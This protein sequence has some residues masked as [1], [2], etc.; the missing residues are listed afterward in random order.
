MRHYI[1]LVCPIILLLLI[2]SGCE[3][4]IVNEYAGD[5]P[6][7]GTA[8]CFGCHSDNDFKLVAARKQYDMSAHATGDTYN[9]NRNNS[10]RYSSCE[11][12][13][14][15]E[16][17]VAAATGEPVTADEFTNVSCFTCHE[18]HTNGTLALRTTEAVTLLNKEVFDHGAGNLCA[19]CHHSRTDVDTEV[20]ANDTLNS[21]YGPHH[22]NQ[23][24]MLIGTN[25]YE[26]EDYD[27]TSAHAHAL[28]EDACLQ[29][30]MAAPLYGT[31]G[32]SFYLANEEEEY[33]NVKGCNT[34]CH[35]GGVE[36]F[37]HN[38]LQADIKTLVDSLGAILLEA[39]LLEEVDDNGV[40][41]LEP[42]EDRVVMTADSLGAVFNY[43]YVLEDRSM[44][45]HNPYYAEDLLKSSIDFMNG[46][47]AKAPGQIDLRPL[48]AH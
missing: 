42:T 39:G 38:D 23:S 3:R 10:S 37:E 1:L 45:I 16:G 32:H 27:Y 30:H 9:R 19:T 2:A 6:P 40:T 5:P 18:P 48:A 46:T 8:V 15:N 25:A 33:D 14:T 29:C 22:S 20:F 34:G 17:F 36:D 13:H 26:Y 24:D 43:V 28:A 41:V 11:P 47:P 4:K 21:R 31:G 7:G 12:C 35:N 44:G